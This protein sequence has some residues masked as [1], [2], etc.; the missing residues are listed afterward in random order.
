MNRFSATF[1]ASSLL[2]IFPSTSVWAGS[3]QVEVPLGV[4][5]S[6]FGANFLWDSKFV[7]FE[8]GQVIKLNNGEGVGVNLGYRFGKSISIQFEFAGF[9]EVFEKESSLF[10]VEYSGQWIESLNTKVPTDYYIMSLIV[11]HPIQDFLP[12]L[13]VGLVAIMEV[14]TG[15]K[16]LLPAKR[17]SRPAIVLQVGVLGFPFRSRGVGI[18]V[19]CKRMWGFLDKASQTTIGANSFSVGIQFNP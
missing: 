19:D 3:T 8:N 10:W 7:R 17:A 18:V 9:E 6:V 2:A 11:H 13:G 4:Y 14:P 1:V 16:G 12:F 5:A 15:Y